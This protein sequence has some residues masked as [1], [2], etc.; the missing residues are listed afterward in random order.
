MKKLTEE[1]Y[2]M[3]INAKGTNLTEGYEYLVK[4]VKVFKGFG[5]DVFYVLDNGL[6]YASCHFTV[7]YMA[8][9]YK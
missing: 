3:C 7:T 4:K 6:A 2:A 5:E 9:R 1:M 8:K